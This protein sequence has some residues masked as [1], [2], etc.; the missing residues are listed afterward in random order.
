MI[1]QCEKQGRV[2]V[3]IQM[4]DMCN[5]INSSVICRTQIDR[6]RTDTGGKIE[7]AGKSGERN[8]I[9]PS[10]IHSGSKGSASHSL[11]QNLISILLINYHERVEL[12]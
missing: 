12:K 8:A 9:N 3:R 7:L 11:K 5:R 1:I 6:K 4:S 10:P 2:K